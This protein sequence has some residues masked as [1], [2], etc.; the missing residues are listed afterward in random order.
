MGTGASLLVQRARPPTTTPLQT[1][2]QALHL[3]HIDLAG[4]YETTP[5]ERVV[6]GPY[7]LHL[8]A[9]PSSLPLQIGPWQ[10][11]D[12][13][14]SAEV[15]T[16][17]AHPDLVIRR[18]YMDPSGHVI[19]LLVIGSRGPKSFRL[20]EHTPEICYPSLGWRAL[21]VDVTTVHLRDGV[22][23]VRRGVYERGPERHVVYSWYQWD[24]PIRDAAKGITS[25]RLAT[26]A[27]EGLEAA[28]SRL[29]DFIRQL[30]YDVLPW[31]RF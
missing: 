2:S 22:I 12:L 26:E 8:D 13:G 1:G 30:F 14:P 31:R 10:G 11:A 4:W 5:N 24:N 25:W 20:F 21:I 3:V 19:W 16:F 6:Y 28:Q 29:Q 17:F 27:R 23:S 9:L 18:E 7:D 15:E